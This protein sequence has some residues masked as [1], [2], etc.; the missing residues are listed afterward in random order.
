MNFIRFSTD[1]NVSLLDVLKITKCCRDKESLRKIIELNSDIKH[2]EYR[3]LFQNEL[4]NSENN[5]TKEFSKE[6]NSKEGF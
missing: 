4:S 3:I 6:D 1:F 2:E 5:F